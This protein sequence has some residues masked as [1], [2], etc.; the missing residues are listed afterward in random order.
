VVPCKEGRAGELQLHA[1][2][3]MHVQHQLSVS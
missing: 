1:H 2:G 3:M